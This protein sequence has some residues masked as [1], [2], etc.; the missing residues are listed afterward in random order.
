MNR[1]RAALARAKMHEAIDEL[2]D[3]LEE[4][5]TSDPSEL[6]KAKPRARKLPAPLHPVS[7][8]DRMKAEQMLRRQGIIA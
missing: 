5:S 3:A 6:K 7:D 8:I 4:R 1:E 2:F